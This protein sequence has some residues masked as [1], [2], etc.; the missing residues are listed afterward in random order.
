MLIYLHFYKKQQP[1]IINNNGVSSIKTIGGLTPAKQL[2]YNNNIKLNP[3]GYSGFNSK[4]NHF[5]QAI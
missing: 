5:N 4:N 3:V 2:N 1:V